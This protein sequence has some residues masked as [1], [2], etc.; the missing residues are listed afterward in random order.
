MPV[1]EMDVRAVEVPVALAERRRRQGVR[2]PREFQEVAPPE[3]LVHIQSF[4]PGNAGVDMG[5]GGALIHDPRRAGGVTTMTAMMGFGRKALRRCDGH[6]H[7]RRHG[8]ELPAARFIAR[9]AGVTPASSLSGFAPRCLPRREVNYESS[10]SS[11][12]VA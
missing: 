3:R 2:L 6:G 10:E 8:A 1:C 11:F 12:K 7:D 4:D 9:E 5:G